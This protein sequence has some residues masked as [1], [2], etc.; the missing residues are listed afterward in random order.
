MPA[1]TSLLRGYAAAFALL[2]LH[3]ALATAAFLRAGAWPYI[4]TGAFYATSALTLSLM[5]LILATVVQTLR[6]LWNRAP[7]P[8]RLVARQGRDWLV[9]R[10]TGAH[11]IV[12]LVAVTASLSIF[13][14]VKVSIPLLRPFTHDQPFR[15]LDRLI[16]AGRDPYEW[17]LP[18][19]GGDRMLA[20]LNLIYPAWLVCL[21]LSIT[22]LMFSR[23]HLRRIRYLIAF[24]LSFAV[25]GNLL[26]AVFS[27][28][29]PCFY[30]Q[31]LG[32]D[33]FAPLMAHLD[34][35]A[36]RTGFDWSVRMQALFWRNFQNWDGP[37]SGISAMPSMH[38]LVAWLWV[39]LLWPNR[40]LGGAALVFALATFIGSVMLGWH[41]AVDGIAGAVLAVMAWAVAGPLAARACAGW[42]RPA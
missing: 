20:A 14:S 22:W 32:D 30:Q 10:A 41:Y 13:G 1:L 33:S 25:A 12:T 24:I 21:I 15:D 17:L 19:F 2:A 34:A 27:S 42:A 9:T 26:A 28:A 18:V 6:A 5:V 29:G 37:I 11:A 38:N 36:G 23:H 39:F 8:L 16:F 35:S 7:N 31:V 3:L 40:W 4:D